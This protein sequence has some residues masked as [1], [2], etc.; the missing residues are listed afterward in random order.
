MWNMAVA[1]GGRTFT[2]T[3]TAD[4]E[5]GMGVEAAVKAQYGIS[6]TIAND[7]III[8][9]EAGVEWTSDTVGQYAIWA[10]N[11][12]DDAHL[13]IQ[14]DDATSR[15]GGRGGDG[16]A[17]GSVLDVTPIFPPCQALGA[18]GGENGWPAISLGCNTTVI[19][20]GTIEM[21]Y[22]GG[23]GGGAN[24]GTIGVGEGGGGGQH[25]GAAG[26]AGTIF[27][28]NC[29]EQGAPASGTAGSYVT[30]GTGGSGHATNAD[31]GD[32]G[33]DGNA[34]QAGTTP[35]SGGAGGAAG[36]NANAVVLNGFTWTAEAGV[37]VTGTVS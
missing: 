4:R 32:G 26:V 5:L 37:T 34:P 33:S 3:V 29:V 10:N 18:G 23:G 31:G 28:S 13:I 21:G 24:I 14:L 36:A 25:K 30:H 2:L 19:G 15:V 12:H 17:G 22:G 35:A 1:A 27:G 20:L 11:L 9:V 6:G 7:R 8:V 16:G